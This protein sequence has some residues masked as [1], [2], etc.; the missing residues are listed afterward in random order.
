MIYGARLQNDSKVTSLVQR[1]NW[2]WPDD[3]MIRFPSLRQIQIPQLD[4]E[5]SDKALWVTRTRQMTEYSTKTVWID[6]ECDNPKVIWR[7]LIWFAQ[8]IPRHSFVLW[9][10]NQNRPMTH[11]RVAVW[12][13]NEPMK[14]VLC[15]LCPDSDHLFFACSYSS[16]VWNEM[17]KTLS[18]RIIFDWNNTVEE[19]S[20]MKANNSID[21]IVSRLVFGAVVYFIWQER[22]TR[23]FKQI[24]R[25]KE[26]LVQTIKETLR[27]RMMIFSVK[28]SKA[29]RRMEEI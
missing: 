13:P 26:S 27:L 28:E 8:C 10:E 22:N 2:C 1:G 17:L 18:K 12:K 7:H 16:L 9:M 25:N 14:C 23:M 6:M 24:K 29:V 3:W 20:K 5:I 15:A 4:E 21:S 11:D 19:I